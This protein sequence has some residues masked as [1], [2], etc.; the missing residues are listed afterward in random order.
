MGLSARPHEAYTRTAIVLHWAIALM[1]LGQ[2]ALGWWM[3]DIPKSPPGV[4]AYWFN[5]HKSIGLTIGAL[6]LVRLLWRMGHPA[7]ILPTAVPAW[8]RFAAKVSHFTLYACLV[9]LPVTGYLGSNFTKY[10]I[11][12]LGTR[13][14]HWGW[15]APT[16]KALCSDIH[17]ATV[18]VFM[19][20]ITVHAAAALKHLF[21]NRDGVFQRMWC[22][23]RRAP[24]HSAVPLRTPSL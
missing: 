7:P 10:P 15:D 23:P 8:Q 22:W 20:L 2:L 12:F 24:A 1:L 5:L 21:V 14:P 19:I 9:I 17:Y 6:V 3:I 18:I 11:I 13:L 16:W 4:R